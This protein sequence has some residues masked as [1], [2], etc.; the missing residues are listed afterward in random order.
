MGANGIY[1]LSGSGLD[2]ESLVKMGMMNKQNQY[3]KMYQNEVKQ[4]W[5]KEAYNDVYKDLTTFKYS[6]LSDF[7]M[8]SNMSAMTASSSDSSV[9]TVTANG[10]AAAMNHKVTV[11]S[12][13]SN[14]Y[15][16]TADQKGIDRASTKTNSD[17][18]KDVLYKR[19]SSVGNSD[20]TY[21]YKLT[22]ADGT[23]KTVNGSDTAISIAFRDTAGDETTYTLTYTYDDLMQQEKTLYDFASD[24][25]KTG[26]NIQGG[27]DS[28]NNSFSIYNKTS[29]KDN[30]IGILANNKESAQLL[31]SLNLG[32]YD[33][34]TDTLSGAISFA[35][36]DVQPTTKSSSNI[37]TLSQSNSLKDVL[38]LTATLTQNGSNY[39]FVVKDKDGR[40]VAN[41]TGKTLSEIKNTNAFSINVSDGTDNSD[42]SFTYGDLFNLDNGQTGK[43]QSNAT[44]SDFAD[45]INAAG[46]GGIKAAYDEAA[47]SFSMV[48]LTGEAKLTSADDVGSQMISALNLGS[49]SNATLLESGNSLSGKKLADL[50]GYTVSIE[51]YV[52]T[53]GGTSNNNYRMTVEDS[54]GQAVKDANGNAI[55]VE[56]KAGSFMGNSST[57]AKKVIA[58]F[59]IGDGENSA[60]VN[61]KAS[62]LFDFSGFTTDNGTST[63]LLKLNNG[64]SIAVNNSVAAPKNNASDAGV[65]ADKIT[66]AVSAGGINV[67]ADYDNG[68]LSLFNPAGDV[69]L[70]GNDGLSASLGLQ[71]VTADVPASVVSSGITRANSKSTDNYL[72][73]ILGTSASVTTNGQDNYTITMKDSSGKENTY[74]G[75]AAELADMSVFSLA[76]GDSDNSVDVSVTLGELFDL[77]SLGSA[78]GSLRANQ[79][80]DLSALAKKINDATDGK[81]NVK[82]SY[83]TQSGTFALEN[84]AGHVNFTGKDSLGNTLVKNLGIDAGVTTDGK[85]RTYAGSNASVTIDGKSFDLATNKQT[86]AG[87]TYTFTGVTEPGKT[88]NVSVTQDTDKIIEYVNKF[89]DE[90]NKLIDGL[91]EKISEEKYSDYKPLTK[92]QEEEMSE[93]QIKKWNEK[94][95]SGLLYHDNTIRSLISDMREAVYMPVEAV[96][97]KYNSLS[98]IGITTSNNKGH[99]TLDETKLRTALTEDPDCV[100]QLFA[101]DQDS[102]YVAGSADKVVISKEQQKDDFNNT[103]VANRL[104]NVMTNR[105]SVISSYAGTSAATDDQSYLGKLITNLQTKMSNFKTMMQSYENVL[106]KKYDAMEVALSKLGAQLG[107]ITG[108][109]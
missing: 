45:R 88:A 104:T 9:V 15:L 81:V 31:N 37:K 70:E 105:M 77:S 46:V 32:S 28:A 13:A 14:A 2:I 22:M 57:A 21:E 69:K 29:G 38:G 54:S 87:V 26:A 36:E 61:L 12:V 102:S 19:V 27:Y 30:I 94:A 78:D 42:V 109:N 56:G 55:V 5:L 4:T 33:A 34:N 11:S 99:L 24:I 86:V 76:V 39:D 73:D 63:G 18:L 85:F 6:T 49:N 89:V 44:L 96:D 35:S 108:G 59:T 47:D 40:E 101:S 67:T 75:T 107:Y 83:N 60:S 82:A 91:N 84:G 1:G 90:Y 16:L 53:V 95:K 106:Y 100:Y 98:A 8:Q 3:D 64:T 50:F 58:S 23:T 7:K 43:V 62:D 20:G 97:S 68:K 66:A 92:K 52:S 93:E 71:S 48:N 17:N 10:A 79:G 41:L 74:T 65:L 72:A 51:R 103:G 80:T 25:S